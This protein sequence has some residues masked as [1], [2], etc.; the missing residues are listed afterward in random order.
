MGHSTDPTAIM[1]PS[2]SLST[3]SRGSPGPAADDLAGIRFIYPPVSTPTSAPGA[4]TGLITS[5]SGSTVFLA[6][7]AP[8]SGGT[9]TAHTHEAGSGPRVAKPSKLPPGQNPTSVSSGRGRASAAPTR[10]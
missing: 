7:A 8:S 4:P 3:C 10:A 6:W 9:A 1:Y 5:S 2:V